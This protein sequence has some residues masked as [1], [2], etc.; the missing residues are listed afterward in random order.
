[1]P[2]RSR[3]QPQRTCVAC[4]QTGDKRGLVR[5]VRTPAGE[6]SIDPTGKLAGR[7]AYLCA[8]QSCWLQALTKRSLDRALKM[9]LD[10]AVCERLAEYARELPAD[11]VE[12]D[13]GTT[14]Q[15]E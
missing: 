4:R 10:S 15:D 8:R 9:T 14:D 13:A 5:I 3:R 1:M 6:V 11:A 2:R 7:G 12:A